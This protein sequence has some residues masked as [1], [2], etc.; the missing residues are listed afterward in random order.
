V[1]ERRSSRRLVNLASDT[2]ALMTGPV[3]VIDGSYTTV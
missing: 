2:F 3:L 1:P